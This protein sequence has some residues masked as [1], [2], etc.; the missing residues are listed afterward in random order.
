MG[1]PQPEIQHPICIDLS[2][3]GPRTIHLHTPQNIR[4]DWSFRMNQPYMEW[5]SRTN[6]KAN[7]RVNKHTLYF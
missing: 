1:F 7:Q 5:L 6:I 3:P 2:S 4:C